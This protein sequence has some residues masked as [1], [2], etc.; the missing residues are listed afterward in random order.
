MQAPTPMRVGPQHQ[1]HENEEE[2]A[3]EQEHDASV[4]RE[5]NTGRRA[6]QCRA[7]RLSDRATRQRRHILVEG[8]RR[9]LDALRERQVRV[10]RRCEILD[11]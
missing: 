10:E 2:E 1:T 11:G 4:L 8:E 7:R 6:S 9:E 5:D 3:R